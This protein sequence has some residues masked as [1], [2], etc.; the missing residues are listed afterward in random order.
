LDAA[1]KDS[2]ADGITGETGDLVDVEFRCEIL[3]MF[4]DRLGADTKFPRGLVVGLV[5]GNQ[6]E[7][8]IL[9]RTQV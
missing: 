1:L 7:L 9:A 5:F 4:F 2:R 6:L 3:S 8:S